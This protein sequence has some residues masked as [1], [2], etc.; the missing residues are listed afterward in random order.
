[1]S[2]KPRVVCMHAR[3]YCD[4]WGEHCCDCDA[5]ILTAEELYGERDD[6]DYL[7]WDDEDPND[8]DKES[9]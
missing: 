1:M 8:Y 9:L 5:L 7:S 3:T 2:A 6:S 4:P